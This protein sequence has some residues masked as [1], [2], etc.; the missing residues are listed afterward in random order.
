MLYDPKWE[1]PVET[2]A[3]F[4]G[5]I[6]WLEQQN[7]RERYEWGNITSCAVATYYASLGIYVNTPDR[8]L[9]GDIFGEYGTRE[10]ARYGDICCRRPHTYG[11]ALK[12]ARKVAA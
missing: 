10:R 11:A 4:S 5:F 6:A 12:R 3:S 7:P 9:L 2:V 8:P 1:K